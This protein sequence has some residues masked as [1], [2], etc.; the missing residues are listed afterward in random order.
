M[1]RILASISTAI[2]TVGLVGGEER[3]AARFEKDCEDMENAAGCCKGSQ[4]STVGF[5]VRLGLSRLQ[6]LGLQYRHGRY[7]I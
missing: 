7:G 4:C 1:A 2:K 5:G 3:R 6:C